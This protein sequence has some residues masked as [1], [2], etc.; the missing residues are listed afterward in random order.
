MFRFRVLAITGKAAATAARTPATMPKIASG[1][2]LPSLEDRASRAELFLS[3][4]GVG[5]ADLD[6]E[7]V[8]VAE[9]VVE[10]SEDLV[11]VAEALSEASEDLV[12]VAEAEAS[13]DL[14]ALAD[15]EASEDLVALAD[16]EASEDLV[17]EALSDAFAS[18]VFSE[19]VSFDSVVFSEVSSDSDSFPADSGALAS[20]FLT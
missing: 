4:D 5:S 12:V 16:E 3:L 10:E 20:P 13:E 8:V 19:V 18:V 1:V 15:E 6:S 2:G 14:V 9:A 17:A 7:G 11:V